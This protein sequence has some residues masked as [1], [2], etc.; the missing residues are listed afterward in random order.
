MPLG[1]RFY[2]R[3]YLP[4]L[5]FG[6]CA[7]NIYEPCQGGN[8]AALRRIVHVPQGCLAELAAG[9]RIEESS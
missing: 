1:G 4:M 9:Y 6:S 5:K 8:T 7:M 2:G 3:P